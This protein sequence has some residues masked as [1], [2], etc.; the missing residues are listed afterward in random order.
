MKALTFRSWMIVIGVLLAI[1]LNGYVISDEHIEV[2][3]QQEVV[4]NYE[5]Q[6]ADVLYVEAERERNLGRFGFDEQLLRQANRQFKRLE[7]YRPQLT[8]QLKDAE[9]QLLIAEIFCPRDSSSVRPRYA[10]VRLLIKEEGGKRDVVAPRVDLKLVEQEWSMTLPLLDIYESIEKTK[11]DLSNSTA[12]VVAAFLTKNEEALI[13]RIEPWGRALDGSW[14]W[15]AVR[16][17]YP[18][19]EGQMVDYISLMHFMTEI[20]NDE[21]GICK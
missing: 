7:R 19:I 15:E 14:D 1:I 11:E 9:D 3:S 10:A 5:D 12:M 6:L 2:T 20:A 17:K 4:E 13:R 21:D 8:A 18:K 16:E